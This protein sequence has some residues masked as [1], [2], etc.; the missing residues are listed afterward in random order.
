MV[1]GQLKGQEWRIS[2]WAKLQ[3]AHL[4]TAALTMHG[5]DTLIV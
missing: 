3:S 5:A 2:V 4:V 1:D